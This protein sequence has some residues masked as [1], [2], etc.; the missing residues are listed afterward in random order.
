MVT[1]VKRNEQLPIY[2]QETPQPIKKIALFDEEKNRQLFPL[3]KD[4]DIGMG[5]QYENL[6]IES[7]C[8]E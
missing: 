3:V 6:V 4:K 5:T 1:A 7:V 2:T 8:I